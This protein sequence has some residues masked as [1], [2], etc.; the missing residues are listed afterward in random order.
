MSVLLI[1]ASG[2]AREVIAAGMPDVVGVLD[3]DPGMLGTL[4]GG[5]PVVGPAEDAARRDERL[6]VCIGPGR[7]R[8]QVV[9]RLDRAGVAPERY[10]VFVAPG[11]RVGRSSVV[12]AGSILLDG[13]VVTADARLGRHVV[14]MPGCTVTHDDV[15]EDFAT[16]AAGVSLGGGVRVGEAAYLGM[17]ASVRP[18]ATVHAGATVGMGAVVL[19]DVPAGETWAGVPARALPLDTRP[20]PIAETG[21]ARIA[22]PDPLRPDALR[23]DALRPDPLRPDPLRPDP[24]REV[25]A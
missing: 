5:V 6:L 7:S 4:C 21:D 24:L 14:L 10:A 8:R 18:Y 3:D 25:P 11:A 13:A 16:L 1:G 9:R 19:R 15:L 20:I 2:L 17:N 22:V 12:G 23:P